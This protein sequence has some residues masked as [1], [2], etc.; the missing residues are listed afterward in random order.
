MHRTMC[1]AASWVPADFF[2]QQQSLNICQAITR[3]DYANLQSLLHSSDGLDDQGVCGVTVL[4]WA[5][6]E[7]DEIAFE[8]LLE[9]GASPDIVFTADIDNSFHSFKAASTLPLDS[10]Q[11]RYYGL[12]FFELS[13]SRVR[14]PNQRAPYNK[15]SLLHAFIL[16]CFGSTSRETC[17]TVR[18]I[19][20][21]GVDLN[22]QNDGG[23]TA[24]KMALE[25]GMTDECLI[26]LDAGTSPDI[27][28][29]MGQSLRDTL[30]RKLTGDQRSTSGRSLT[31]GHQAVEAWLMA[32]D[33]RCAQSSSPLP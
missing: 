32:Y 9:A 26:M 2:N 24:A 1:N 23:S 27:N 17:D 14:N 12:P 13:L 20:A 3:K 8:M 30:Q 15:H 25:F 10:L 7:R 29:N 21:T 11:H 18:Q 28:D 19:I 31:A 4:H 6:F 22:A 16:N 33:L 5:Y